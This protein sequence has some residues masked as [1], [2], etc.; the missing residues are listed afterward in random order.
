[1]KFVNF[2]VL[3]VVCL[4]YCNLGI[5]QGPTNPRANFHAGVH[6]GSWTLQRSQLL[7]EEKQDPNRSCADPYCARCAQHLADYGH[8]YQYL[9]GP[10][11]RQLWY[12]GTAGNIAVTTQR[13]YDQ[14]GIPYAWRGQPS[15]IIPWEY[16]QTLNHAIWEQVNARNAVATE[17]AAGDR[18]LLLTKLLE[19][20]QEQLRLTKEAWEQVEN[21][22][23][24]CNK[25]HTTGKVTTSRCCKPY[26]QFCAEM[27]AGQYEVAKSGMCEYCLAQ[28]R[29]LFDQAYVA[30]VERE[31]ALAQQHLTQSSA[32]A[33][34]AVRIALLS[35]DDAD[36]A[37]RFKRLQ[38]KPPKYKEV[39]AAMEAANPEA[40]PEPQSKTKEEQAPSEK[41]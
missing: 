39:L 13:G 36:R 22:V 31:L 41:E 23:E 12:R 6:S 5:A 27:K 2:A 20:A 16:A 24:P 37:T 35:K 9:G 17:E 19:D 30:D 26:K 34:E 1:M 40:P 4:V 8:E 32:V 14:H 28:S 21:T 29:Y 38:F 10:S 11:Q 3:T 25:T 18:V 15:A 7:E 33:T